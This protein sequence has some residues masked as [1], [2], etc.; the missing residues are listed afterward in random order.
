MNK[1]MYHRFPGQKEGEQIKILI[2]K[3]WIVDIKVGAVLTV[4]AVIP[5]AI[6][7]ALSIIFWPGEVT[8]VYLIILLVF[9]VYLMCAGLFSFIKWLNE[10]LDVIIITNERII[11][12]DQVDF[13]HTQISETDISQ[14]QDVKGV[15][16]GF[17]GSMFHYGSLQI[18]TAANKI[19]FNIEDVTRPY[20]IARGILDIR[21]RYL[22][23]EKFEDEP[24]TPP[25]PP[26]L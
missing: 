22:D 26:V 14:V 16:K 3:H 12:H 15:E 24:G 1:H 11:G 25:L 21:D 9:L 17:F 8:E 19:V 5:T 2:R 7:I 10:E 20:E 18:Q 13:F 6:F 4:L 23:K